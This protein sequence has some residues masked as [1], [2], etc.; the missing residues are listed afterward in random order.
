[1]PVTDCTITSTKS[2]NTRMNYQLFLPHDYEGNTNAQYPVIL[3]LHGIKKRGKNIRMLDHYGLVWHAEKQG[4]FPFIVAAPQCPAGS[5]W[6]EQFETLRAL[7]EELVA[8]DLRT[9]SERVYVSG[10]SLGGNGAFDFA[11]RAPELI[12]AAVPIAGFY[13]PK[14]AERLKEMPIWAFHSVDD[15]VVSVSRT[16]EMEEAITAINGNIKTTYYEGLRH[17]HQVMYET[18]GQNELIDWLLSQ[19]RVR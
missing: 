11:A 2:F 1:M 3:F 9:D 19:K 14:L 17:S 7:V 18:Y 8:G 13:D 10:F 12:A 4:D 6:T 15:D 5:D 16:E